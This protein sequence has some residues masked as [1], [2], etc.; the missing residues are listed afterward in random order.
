M[1][2]IDT[3]HGIR[4]GLYV[5]VFLIIFC[6]AQLTW[7]IIYQYDLNR[8]IYQNQISL[9]QIKAET[10][11]DRV[12]HDFRRLSDLAG[13]A[14]QTS[15]GDRASLEKCLANL[16]S[17]K[18]VIGY[19]LGDE[20]GGEVFIGDIDS[21]FYVG[22]GPNHVLYF[23]R[24][25]P[26]NIINGAAPELVF[27]TPENSNGEGLNWVSGDMFRII[28]EVR[29]RI[30]DESASGL[31]MF[32]FEGSFFM[33]IVLS[34]A[35]LI[36]RTLQKSEDL[37]IRQ[38]NFTQAVTHEFR[39]PLTSLRLYLETLE[40]GKLDSEQA[41]Q[42]YS[43][44]LDD[45]DR[46]DSMVDN[47]LEAGHFG[48]EK[49]ELKLTET[50]LSADINDY[51]NEMKPYL[52]RQNGRLK[53]EIQENIRVRSDYHALGRAVR[54]LV[55]NA[56]KYSPPERREITVSLI[57]S[58]NFAIITVSDK[59]VGI[60]EEEQ[61]KVFERFYRV[62]DIN[63]KSVKGTG[64]GLYLV[65]HIAEAH[66]GQVGIVSEGTDRGTSVNI[67]LPLVKS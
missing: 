31:K 41:V 22:F 42:L 24:K 1:R 17:D 11:A 40:S 21:T 27:E 35:Y 48:R 34:R 66:M 30:E 10:L 55:D 67:K 58:G 25:Y 45:C 56:L 46:L 65:C 12:N 63:R 52:N 64:L 6:L 15:G 3:P 2:L 32:I 37:K 14:L 59:G 61:R 8:Q 50:D 5:F 60:P 7:W 33:I 39:T 43:K 57:S 16:L 26:E 28:P 38:V 51:L 9:L 4:F 13:L 49:Y 62:T 19:C 54:A 23:D 53:L 47:V 20:S 36:Y 18:A 44:M 29:Q